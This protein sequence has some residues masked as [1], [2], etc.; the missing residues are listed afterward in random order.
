M[1]DG[2]CHWAKPRRSRSPPRDACDPP[3]VK[4]RQIVEVV[5][6]PSSLAPEP[7]RSLVESGHNA[8]VPDSCDRRSERLQL[9]VQ[10]G[11][12]KRLPN[13]RS[14]TEASRI[15]SLQIL[16]S[17]H[18]RPLPLARL[19]YFTTR[20]PSGQMIWKSWARE[21][22]CSAYLEQGLRFGAPGGPKNSVT[23]PTNLVRL[24]S[25]R[26]HKDYARGAGPR[27]GGSEA[28]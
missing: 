19:T 12:Q 21:S 8:L 11:F 16:C 26:E 4:C 5:G 25:F 7:T 1:R 2:R 9:R 14:P 22:A 23:G 18:V 13:D 3:P 17:T 10:P 27:L 28:D 24:R 15:P 6:E 20:K